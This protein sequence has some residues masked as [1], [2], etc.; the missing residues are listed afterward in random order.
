[1]YG[2][3]PLSPQASI[4][5]Y[6][7]DD[8]S[9]HFHHQN[10]RELLDL[11]AFLP[12]REF[13]SVMAPSRKCFILAFFIVFSFSSMNI[14]LAARHLLQT[15]VPSIPTLPVVPTLPRPTLPPLPAIPTLPQPTQPTLPT[16]Q[17]SL[18][19]PT[20][21]PFPSF[22]TIPTSIPNFNLPPLPTIPSF[23]TI[24]TTIPSIPF[25]SPPPATKSPWFMI[26][27]RQMDH[28]AVWISMD[29]TYIPRT[30]F[31]LFQSK[32]VSLDRV[33]ATFF[34]CWISLYGNTV[35]SLLLPEYFIVWK[36]NIWCS[37]RYTYM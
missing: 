14:S 1:M 10:S 22:P 36:I 37:Y 6:K 4:C 19:K 23:P 30:L 16:T 11:L 33:S 5:L 26:R 2:G 20:L 7:P 29:V 9:L 34:Y 3:R 35:L 25:L 28:F 8:D 31:N 13:R 21:P 17:P 12:H 32:F 15:S 27:N 24:P 18:P